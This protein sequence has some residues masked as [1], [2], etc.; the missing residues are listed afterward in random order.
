MKYLHLFLVTFLILSSFFVFLSDNPVHSVLFLILAFCNASSILFLFNVDFLGVLFIIIYVGAIA[1]LFLF[2]VMMLNVKLYSTQTSQYIPFIFLGSLI[3]LIQIFLNLSV[4]FDDHIDNITFSVFGISL[5][6]LSNIDIFGQGLYNY[7]LI[8]FL[9]AG[10]I[11][12]VA[13]IGAIVLTLNYRSHRK[14]ELFS[15]QLSRSDNF[16][17]FF[18]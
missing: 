18:K 13:M 3:L 8:T 7:F 4:I 14:T 10:L 16:I 2:V 12:L 5:D 17:S 6:N 11:L 9:I 15:K 1:V